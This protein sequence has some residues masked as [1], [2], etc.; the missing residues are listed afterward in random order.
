MTGSDVCLVSEQRS[1]KVLQMVFFHPQ[2]AWVFCFRGQPLFGGFE[3]E[4]KRKTTM[5]VF[6]GYMGPTR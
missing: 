1:V 2:D 6:Y 5:Y 4:T 3:G